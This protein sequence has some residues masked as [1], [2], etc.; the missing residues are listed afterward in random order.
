MARTRKTNSRK[1]RV[2]NV[3][4]ADFA[5]A[6]KKR[7]AEAGTTEREYRRF[8]HPSPLSRISPREEAIVLRCLAG[9]GE[10]MLEDFFDQLSLPRLADAIATAQAVGRRA[11]GSLPSNEV[12]AWLVTS[13]YINPD[14][15][16]FDSSQ[17]GAN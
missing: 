1:K 15:G 3:L 10:P 7:E 12:M 14:K 5:G 4:K 9:A 6:R 17:V 13:F 2:S 11:D 16:K 8:L